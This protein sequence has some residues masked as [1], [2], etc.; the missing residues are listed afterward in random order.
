MGGLTE[1]EWPESSG[2]FECMHCL[3]RAVVWDSDFDFEDYG[4]EGQGIVHA[5]HCAN[6]GAEVLY[7]IPIG[8]NEDEQE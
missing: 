2:L 7:L 8:D 3:K 5:C 1:K 6:C 4:Y